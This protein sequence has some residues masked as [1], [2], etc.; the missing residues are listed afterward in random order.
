MIREYPNRYER[1]AAQ[2]KRVRELYSQIG[3]PL[4]A[5]TIIDLYRCLGPALE[6]VD[7]HSHGESDRTGQ[8]AR[9]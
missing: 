1:V 6:A 8:R 4:P 3:E 2:V 7:G 9:A 5:D